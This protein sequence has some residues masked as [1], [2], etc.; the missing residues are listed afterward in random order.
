[1]FGVLGLLFL[2]GALFAG[3][4]Y[5]RG[6]ESRLWLLSLVPTAYILGTL[7][8]L[9]RDDRT[10]FSP[11]AHDNAASVA[12]ALQV[13][14]GLTRL[15]LQ[16]TEVWLAFTGAEETDHAGLYA[17]LRD[18]P[19]GLRDADFIGLEGLGSGR[20]TYLKQEG[21]CQHVGPDPELLATA[22]RVA[23]DRPELDAG[24]ARMTV[25]DEVC[26]LRRLGHRA[27]CIAGCDPVTG[28]LPHWHRLDDTADTV[29]EEFMERAVRYVRALLDDLDQAGDVLDQGR[30][31][32]GRDTEGA[33]CARS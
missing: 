16:N 2:A 14:A 6:D 17:L 30:D 4:D 21:L 8:T 15:P 12:V 3:S 33:E 1:M 27:I 29:S 13:A 24:P 23:S 28:T 7:V 5:P 22:A 18:D 9:I 31:Q 26:T 25:E 20:L 19:T 10:P 11:G 32:P